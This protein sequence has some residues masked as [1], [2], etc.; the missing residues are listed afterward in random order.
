MRRAKERKRLS[1]RSSEQVVLTRRRKTLWQVANKK[2]LWDAKSPAEQRRIRDRTA[3]R[4]RVKRAAE[5]ASD[6]ERRLARRRELR[7]LM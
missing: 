5:P 6:R 4:A 7:R 3:E 1:R 2:R